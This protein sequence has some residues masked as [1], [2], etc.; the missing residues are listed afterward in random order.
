MHLHVGILGQ[1]GSKTGFISKMQQSIT[2][3]IFL[4]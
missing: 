2:F 3:K 4:L 1:P